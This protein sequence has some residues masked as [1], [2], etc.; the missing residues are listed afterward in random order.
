M[1]QDLHSF[2]LLHF[3]NLS[4]SLLYHILRLRSEVFVV[5]QHCAYQDCDQKDTDAY[6]LLLYHQNDI[7]AYCRILAPGISYPDATA[8]GRVLTPLPYRGLGLGQKLMIEAISQSRSIFPSHP[9]R[10]SAQAHLTRFYSS[11]GFVKVSA[12]YLEDDIP[13]IEMLLTNEQITT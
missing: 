4:T 11:L 3:S 7:A 12:E 6:H 13:H 8:I 10:I 1:T 5:E 2:Q 9:I